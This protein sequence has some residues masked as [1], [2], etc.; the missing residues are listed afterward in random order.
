MSL[1]KEVSR[2]AQ[3]KNGLLISS[4]NLVLPSRLSGVGRHGWKIGNRM[5][6]PKTMPPI[7]RENEKRILL[8]GKT[9][10]V[11]SPRKRRERY[12]SARH[13]NTIVESTTVRTTFLVA[14]KF[15]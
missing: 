6:L 1:G 5:L 8:L 2:E 13:N 12:S 10:N 14:L 15:D 3:S 7:A 9:G 11:A 4:K